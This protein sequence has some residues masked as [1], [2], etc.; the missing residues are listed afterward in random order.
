[1][2]PARPFGKQSHWQA[3]SRSPARPRGRDWP[4]LSPGGLRASGR[5]LPRASAAGQ[6]RTLLGLRV[7][8]DSATQGRAQGLGRRWRRRHRDVPGQLVV[9]PDMPP[10]ARAR[11]G[12][13]LAGCS[14]WPVT[15]A[16][17]YGGGG[18]A[19]WPGCRQLESQQ[20]ERARQQ[21]IKSR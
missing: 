8:R 3:V 18:L 21:L 19:A 1:M 17:H 7:G 10:A 9:T 15:G 2:P 13:T 4:W 16:G 14:G 20:P 11:V 12:Q 5:A 6:T